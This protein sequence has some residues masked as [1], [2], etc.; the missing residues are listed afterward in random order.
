MPTY[1]TKSTASDLSPTWTNA[2]DHDLEMSA[3]T[4]ATNTQTWSIPANGLES[5][6]WITPSDKPN[7]DVWEDSGTW[8]VRLNVTANNMNMRARCRC[9]RLDLNGVVLQ[10]GAFTPFQTMHPIESKTFSPVAPAW[11]D[12]EEACNNRLAIEWEAE[13]LDGMMTQSFDYEVDL[14]NSDTVTDITEDAGTCGGATPVTKVITGRYDIIA[15]VTKLITGRYDVAEFV[16]KAITGRYDILLFATKVITG[17]YDILLFVNKVI[18]GRFDIAQFVTK[19]FTGR[20]D[21]AGKVTKIITGRYDITEFITKTITGRY[22]ILIAATKVIT[23]R[24]D[25]TA[26]V[27]KIVTGRYDIAQFVTKAITGRY[28]ILQFVTKTITGRF[29]ITS[30][31]NKMI[32]GRYDIVIFAKKVITGRFDILAAGAAVKRLT[33]RLRDL[34]RF[35]PQENSM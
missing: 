22:D 34:M 7:S 30:F 13:N 27:T 14:G 23:G 33:R 26:F 24:Y 2:T 5:A 15:F 18:T 12:G 32:T 4:A 6:G 28:D 8:T 25:I 17:R 35:V 1:N 21:L 20:Y 16:T 31:V 29:D 11:T 10:S 19:T 9:V 3:G